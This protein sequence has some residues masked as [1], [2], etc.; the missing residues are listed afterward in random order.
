MLSYVHAQ[1]ATREPGVLRAFI[2]VASLEMRYT[3]LVKPQDPTMSPQSQRKADL[4]KENASHA[5]HLAIQDLTKVLDRVA[6]DPN[7]EEELEILF[8]MWFLILHFG[9]YDS[10]LVRTSYLHLNGIRTFVAEYFHQGTEPKIRVLPPAAK[11]LMVFIC[12]LDIMLALGGVSDG[13]LSFDLMRAHTAS[14]VNFDRLFEEARVCVPQLWGSDYPVEELLDDIENYR[15]LK[16]VNTCQKLKL[17]IWKFGRSMDQET[18]E[19]LMRDI[20]TTGQVC[21]LPMDYQSCLMS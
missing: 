13:E 8:S 5:L 10:D 11:Q 20:E 2:A 12:Y 18:Q 21:L 7:N 16:F 19:N 1:V 4:F 3:E 15:P 14:P 17:R 6:Q 9:I